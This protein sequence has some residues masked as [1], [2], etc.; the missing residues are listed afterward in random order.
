MEDKGNEEFRERLT[1]LVDEIIKGKDTPEGE[2]QLLEAKKKI[3]TIT[4]KKDATR[5]IS[6]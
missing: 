4:K 1:D 3:I 2:Q 6:E 5:E